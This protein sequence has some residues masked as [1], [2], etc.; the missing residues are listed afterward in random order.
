LH[1]EELQDLYL[2]NQVKENEMDRACG[3]YREEGKCIRG[4][5]RNLRECGHLEDIGICGKIILKQI[6]KK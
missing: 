6:F 5:N 2:F 3:S 1:K 4:F